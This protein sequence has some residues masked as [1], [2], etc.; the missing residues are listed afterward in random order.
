V[1]G[2]NPTFR[3]SSNELRSGGA[4]LRALGVTLANVDPAS[5]AANGVNTPRHRAHVLRRVLEM[6]RSWP[7]YF[8][9]LFVVDGAPQVCFCI[10]TTRGRDVIIDFIAERGIGA[11]RVALGRR[12]G[13]RR[14]RFTIE[15]DKGRTPGSGSGLGR[16][17][18]FDPPA[19]HSRRISAG[20]SHSAR[21]HDSSDD[22]QVPHRRPAGKSET[23][24]SLTIFPRSNL[25][26]HYFRI[27]PPDIITAF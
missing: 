26:V 25:C 22:R 5:S 27:R 4:A 20:A 2:P 3:L 19:D 1:L 21:A 11:G 17:E 16:S 10:W 15:P 6:A 23:T 9:R 8:A 7:F 24:Q 18:T 14:Q 13:S 12:F